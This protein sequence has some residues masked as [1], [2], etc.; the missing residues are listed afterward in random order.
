VNQPLNVAIPKFPI[1]NDSFCQQQSLNGLTPDR[2]L[3]ATS[4]Y[5]S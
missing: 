5:T 2:Q 3:A 1:V 4:G